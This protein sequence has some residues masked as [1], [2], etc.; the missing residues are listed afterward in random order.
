[1]P[2]ILAVVSCLLMRV[3][4]EGVAFSCFHDVS[5]F[6]FLVS[7]MFHGVSMFAYPCFHDDPVFDGSRDAFKK[8]GIK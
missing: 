1:M 3:G 4:G 6:H 8:H 5:I 7:V 2:S